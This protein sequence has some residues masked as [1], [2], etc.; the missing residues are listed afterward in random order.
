[1]SEMV[2]RNGEKVNLRDISRRDKIWDSKKSKA[3]IVSLVYTKYGTSPRDENRARRLKECAGFLRFGRSED[4]KLHLVQAHF[5]RNWK[6]CPIC[7]WRRSLMYKARFYSN[8]PN[9]LMSYPDAR[10][11]FLTL[12]VRNCKIQELRKTIQWMNQA[13]NY[14]TRKSFFKK[15]FLGYIKN[16]E[17][18][19]AED[20]KAHPHF[21]ILLMAKESYFSGKNYLSKIKWQ[22]LWRYYLKIDYDP[23]IDIRTPDTKKKI[24]ENIK[25]LLKY[26]LKEA[27][28]DI[29]TKWFYDYTEQVHKLRFIST[30]GILKNIMKDSEPTTDEELINV[31]EEH[32]KTDAIKELLSFKWY[33]KAKRYKRVF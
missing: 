17:V 26:P 2:T 30:G 19:R 8:M 15:S 18:T 5:C 25:E 3:D 11:I 1:M 21:H 4:N 31:D 13:F 9:I 16:V 27:D 32:Q 33:R 20:G 7:Q 23:I 12:T 24:Q 29:R 6:S 14:L 22:N 28:M 10:Y